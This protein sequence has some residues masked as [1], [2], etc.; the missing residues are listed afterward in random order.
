M[1]HTY[2]EGLEGYHPDQLLHDYCPECEDRS[3][4]NAHGIDHLESERF[5]HAWERAAQWGKHGLD[6]VSF[7]ELPMLRVIVAIQWQ[8]ERVGV[9]T[10]LILGMVKAGKDNGWMAK[11]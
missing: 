3:K 9:P 8:F 11:S 5:L 10:G 4:L 1:S 6:N 7:A 2:H